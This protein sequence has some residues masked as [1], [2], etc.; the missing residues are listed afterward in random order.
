M[1]R[2]RALD[3]AL[4]RF[5]SSPPAR[6]VASVDVLASPPARGGPPPLP[7]SRAYPPASSPEM[8][9]ADTM[10]RAQP[11]PMASPPISNPEVAWTEMMSRAQLRQY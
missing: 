6:S 9:W 8:A 10:S 5:R 7:F 2:Q 11:S 3:T 1:E 4:N